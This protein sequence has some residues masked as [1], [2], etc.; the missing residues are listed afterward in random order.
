MLHR[1]PP[2]S[3]APGR[4]RHGVSPPRR[5]WSGRSR[6]RRPSSGVRRWR[7]LFVDGGSRLHEC[8][9]PLVL[10]GH[11]A[12]SQEG[13]EQILAIDVVEAVI[14]RPGSHSV[15]GGVLERSVWLLG[16]QLL[17]RGPDL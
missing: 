1:F 12:Y 7:A 17:E 13:L 2:A 6:P 3:R 4:C 16:W 8:D 11:F 5:R 14:Q 15:L 9:G 10:A